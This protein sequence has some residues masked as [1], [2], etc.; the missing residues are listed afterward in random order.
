MT[1]AFKKPHIVDTGEVRIAVYD[2]RPDGPT[3]TLPVICLHGF[4]ELAYSWRHQL[5]ALAA[6]GYWGLAPDLR[7][8]GASSAPKDVA[9][10]RIDRLAADVAAV[11]DDAG[12]DRAIVC[13]HDWGALLLWSL[14][15]LMPKRLAGLIALNVP[16]KPRGPTDLVGLLNAAF[17][18]EN[19][20]NFHQRPDEPEALYERDVAR[21][22]RFF[23]RRRSGGEAG[24]RAG[25][26]LARPKL[27]FH[28]LLERDEAEW[29]GECFLTDEELAYYAEAFGKS[30]FFGPV[31]WYRNLRANWELMAEYQPP[32]RPFA[33]IDLPTLLLMADGDPVLP[34]ALADDAAE[35]LSDVEVHIIR[36]CSHWTQQER[37]DE[38]NRLILDWLGRRFP[39]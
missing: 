10:Y 37:P 9:A 1:L 2:F 19:Y 14:V 6:A 27:D 12:I 7:G 20:M 30:G 34:P 31:S 29:P 38:V 33:K 8:Y 18:P 26:T 32:G 11:L 17:G 39:L 4:P 24:E 3:A 15:Y 21:T 35:Y 16:F 5:P 23:M 28:R 22:M 25:A 13:G 36:D